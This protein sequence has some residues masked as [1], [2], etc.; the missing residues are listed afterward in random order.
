[1]YRKNFLSVMVGI[2]F[3]VGAGC[4][5]AD[6]PVSIVD[7]GLKPAEQTTL[8]GTWVCLPHQVTGGM[9]TMECAYGIKT[10]DGKHYALDMSVV[11]LPNDL[12]ASIQINDRVGVSGLVTPIEQISNNTQWSKY[13]V[14]GIIKVSSLEKE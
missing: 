10:D 9:E 6:K 7:P 3:I 8:K 11:T 4:K 5:G 12:V 13:D 1:M 14:R 2:L